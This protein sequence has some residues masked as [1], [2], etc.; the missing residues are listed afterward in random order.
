LTV[1]GLTE[2]QS[3]A[4]ECN[5]IFPEYKKVLYETEELGCFE[6]QDFKL[7]VDQWNCALGME[8]QNEVLKSQ[9]AKKDRQINLLEETIKLKDNDIKLVEE[10]NKRLFEKWEF[11]NQKRHE[12]ENRTD[13]SWLAWTGAAAFATST[14][15]LGTILVLQ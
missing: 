7:I 10:E 2:N 14:V 1:L 6:F 5:D 8:A 4:Q 15:V 9:N 3:L 12:A 13:Y 11:E